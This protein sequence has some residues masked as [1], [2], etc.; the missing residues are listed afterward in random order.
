MIFPGISLLALIVSALVAMA[1]GFAW[2]SNTLFGK[3][4]RSLS[5]ISDATLK[6][7]NTHMPQRLGVALIATLIMVYVLALALYALGADTFML[8]AIVGFWIWLGFVVPIMLGSVLWE[9]KHHNFYL[10]NVLHYLVIFILVGGI[11]GWW[12]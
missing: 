3:K 4:W 7:M 6:K 8:G 12:I 11:L 1:L 5:G 2:Y 9:G 10:I